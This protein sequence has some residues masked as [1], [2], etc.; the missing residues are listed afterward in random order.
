MNFHQGVAQNFHV[1]V[2]RNKSLLPKNIG[3]EKHEISPP[4]SLVLITIQYNLAINLILF[5]GKITILAMGINI[6]YH[7]RLLY[8]QSQGVVMINQ[9]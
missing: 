3:S 6:C 8:I 5:Y 9:G 2:H 4:P 1:N 7:P